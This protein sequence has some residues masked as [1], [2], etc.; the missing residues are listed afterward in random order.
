MI[1]AAYFIGY[2]IGIAVE[3]Y[4]LNVPLPTLVEMK[5]S[6]SCDVIFSSQRPLYSEDDWQYLR[7]LWSSQQQAGKQLKIVKTR[8]N[9][10]TNFISPIQS[11]QTI[12]GKGRGLFATRDIK[13]GEMT[14]NGEGSADPHLIKFT[15]GQSYRKFV[16][17]IEDDG[18]ACDVMLWTYPLKNNLIFQADDTSLMN[19]VRMCYELYIFAINNLLYLSSL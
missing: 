10:N 5:Q 3:K 6:R 12:D 2:V 19:D 9:K 11:G 16:Y 14:Y 7:D 15:D 18:M 17:A 1:G 4:W 8:K 13:K